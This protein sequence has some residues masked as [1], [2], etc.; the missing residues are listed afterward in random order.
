V[1]LDSTISGRDEQGDS[2]VPRVA[3][4]PHWLSTESST[5]HYA[6]DKHGSLQSNRNVLDTLEAVLTSTAVVHRGPSDA[7]LTHVDLRVPDVC[8]VGADIEV[9][10]V[11]AEGKPRSAMAVLLREDDSVVQKKPFAPAED[12]MRARFTGQPEGLYSVRVEPSSAAQGRMTVVT[13]PFM[14]RSPEEP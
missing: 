3:A 14:V 4:T 10:A 13:A 7:N 1:I 5:I 8:P 9:H 6:T 2:T 12:G 11:I